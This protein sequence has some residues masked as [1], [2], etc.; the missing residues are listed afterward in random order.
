MTAMIIKMGRL[1]PP[2][3]AILIPILPIVIV[4]GF[5]WF[6]AKYI[7]PWTR[8]QLRYLYKLIYNAIHNINSSFSNNEDSEKIKE[9]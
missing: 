5:G 2:V 6:V 3:H 7:E 8:K 1:I 4:I 9:K